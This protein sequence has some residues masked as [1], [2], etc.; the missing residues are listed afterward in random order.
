M[1]SSYTSWFSLPYNRL[2][3]FRDVDRG[4]AVVF[5]FPPGDT[6]MVDQKL[7]GHDYYGLLRRE[8]MNLSRVTPQQF[9]EKP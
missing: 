8:A 2:P 5:S 3:G 6:I 9:S 1:T 4:D 7:A